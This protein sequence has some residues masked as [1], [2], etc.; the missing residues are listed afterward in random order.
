MSELVITIVS[1]VT[2]IGWWVMGFMVARARY[3]RPEP[4][5]PAVSTINTINTIE[6][7]G[8]LVAW[9]CRTCGRVHGSCPE[10]SCTL[11]KAA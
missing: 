9:H 7:A 10:P 11:V 2:A 8:H 1:L 4:V 5:I 3:R 6:C